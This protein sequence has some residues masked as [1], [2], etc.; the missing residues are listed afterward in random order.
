MGITFSCDQFLI[1]ACRC[2]FSDGNYIRKMDTNLEALEKAMGKLEGRRKDLLKRV[3][4][5]EDKGLRR[6]FE[7]HEWFSRVEE[8]GFQVEDLFESRSTETEKLCLLNYFSKDCVISYKYGEKVWKKMEEAE[9]LYS[10][11]VFEVLAEEAPIPK[12]EKKHI[13]TTVGLDEMVKRDKEHCY[14]SWV[15]VSKDFQN[16]N[17]QDQIL[18]RLHLDKELEQKTE[19]EKASSIYNLLSR[20]KIVMLLG[21]LWSEVYLNKIGV[22]PVTKENGS[23]IVFTTRSKEVCKHMRADEVM[24]VNCLSQDEAW[25]LFQK[26]VEK[27]TLNSHQDIPQLARE[28]AERCYGLPLA[29]CAIEKTM[30]CKETV[31]EWHHAFDVLK[32][33]CRK[34]PGIEENIL[35]ILKFNYDGLKD[36]KVKLCFFY[37]SLFPEDYEVEKDE[38]IEYWICEKFIDG[39]RDEYEV[40]N[41][42]HDIIGSLFRAHLL[43]DGKETQY[44][45]MHDVIREMALWIVC[46]FGNE[47]DT[48]YVKTGEQSHEIQKDIHWELERRMSLM[49]NQPT[50]ISWST[51][52]STLLFKKKNLV[53]VW[54]GIKSLS[55]G[56]KKLRKLIYLNLEYNELQSID[57]IVASLPDLQVLKLFLS[58]I[59]VDDTLLKELQLLEHL[60]ISTLD[61]HDAKILETI[62]GVA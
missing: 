16:K 2:F 20:K 50:P 33:S 7:V 62:Q 38:L 27:T 47:K 58:G 23:K 43:I 41:K 44:V 54:T 31:Q 61:I 56:L 11:G 18:Q 40:N 5:E 51:N 28:V 1:A 26:K 32:E 35:A 14:V 36:E 46:N 3:D 8:L 19:K 59:C 42:G 60:K 13:Q 15:V 39:N 55:V 49:S 48:F 21:D 57:G 37:Y 22:P 12:V 30:A 6:L 25:E 29:I 17:I 45:K 34:F 24:Q 53:N 9:R 52:L 4:K 10:E